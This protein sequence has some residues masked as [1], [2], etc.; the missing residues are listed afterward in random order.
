MPT[1]KVIYG[2]TLA[3]LADE[4]KIF[5]AA[6]L[7]GIGITDD[8]TAGDVITVPDRAKRSLSKDRL[9]KVTPQRSV[10][11]LDRQRW[12]DMVLQELGDEERMLELID[13]NGVGITDD[14]APGTVVKAPEFES[15]HQKTVNLLRVVH[16]C[17][18]EQAPPGEELEGIEFWG[19]EFDFIVS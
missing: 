14:L 1:T 9:A 8:L 16:P 18:G 5:E 4:E 7:N 10:R 13:L 3:D 15:E 12:V 2:Q 17:S 11:S 6:D 19:I